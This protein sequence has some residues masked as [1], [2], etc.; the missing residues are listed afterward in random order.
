M[1]FKKSLIVFRKELSELL[2]DR[3]TLFTNIILPVILYPLLFV[4]FSAIMSRQAGVIEK[5][6]ATIAYT[7]SLN[8]RDVKSIA[9]RDSLLAKIK[10]LDY[11]TLIPCPKT[12]QQ[13]YE[14][15]EIQA[16]L[17]ISDSLTSSGL[18]TYK[19]YVQHDASNERG[20]MVFPRS[21]PRSRMW[22]RRLSSNVWWLIRSIPRFCP[23]WM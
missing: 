16:V 13:L 3:R 19:V 2:R 4:G 11:V 14:D 10:S 22:K 6:G 8:Q 7:D 9:M 15:K 17:T 21:R 12:V 18:N 23:W 1:N 5:K 20:K